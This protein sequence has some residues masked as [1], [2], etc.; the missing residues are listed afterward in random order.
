MSNKREQRA[1]ECQTCRGTGY[2]DGAQPIKTGPYV[3]EPP[4]C[5]VCG[6][7]VLNRKNE[8]TAPAQF[9]TLRQLVGE[10]FGPPRE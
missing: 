1:S 10:A 4:P 6:G 9:F 7:T 8:L 5:R 3:I 2:V